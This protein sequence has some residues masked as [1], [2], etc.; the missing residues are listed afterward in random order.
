[1]NQPEARE[2]ARATIAR[3]RALPVRNVPSMRPVRQDLSRR[4][5]GESP[6]AVR[7]VAEG[8]ISGGVRWMGYELIH[9]HRATIESLAAADVEA[10]GEGMGSWGDVD[11]FGGYIA[12]P[13]W[14][15]GQ[16]SNAVVAR[17]TRSPDRWWRRA[18]LVATV[19]LNKKSGG[20]TGD[21]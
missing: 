17:W 15:R 18:A 4:L 6:A 10:L 9:A 1:M 16:I 21:P 11:T 8:L 7:A 12:G 19:S 5:R 13:A 2:L 14:L 20:G 3:L